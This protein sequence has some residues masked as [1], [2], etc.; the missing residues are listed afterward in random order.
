M[1]CEIITDGYTDS[2]KCFGAEPVYRPM[3]FGDYDDYMNA[4][5][6]ADAK[7]R[8]A[9]IGQLICDRIVSWNVTKKGEKL[10]ITPENFNALP[11]AVGQRLRNLI[12]GQQT[13]DDSDPGDDAKN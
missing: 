13:A 10:E 12:T 4:V 1:G 3:P 2:D 8:K 11:A 6:A 7:D 5:I 9:I